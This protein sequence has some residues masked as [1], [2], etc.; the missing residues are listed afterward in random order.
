MPDD[1]I[2]RIANRVRIELEHA[3]NQP[4]RPAPTLAD[5]GQQLGASVDQIRAAMLHLDGEHS[6]TFD[7]EHADGRSERTPTADGRRVTQVPETTR[8]RGISVRQYWLPRPND[9]DLLSPAQQLAFGLQRLPDLTRTS[10]ERVV[11]RVPSLELVDA[12]VRPGRP[13]AV[14]ESVETELHRTRT[15]MAG[16]DREVWEWTGP[17]CVDETDRDEAKRAGGLE[18]WLRQVLGSRCVGV[19]VIH[20]APGAEALF[21]KVWAV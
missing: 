5:L 18:P 20:D 19:Q 12:R 14:L 3:A 11:A 6:V 17:L 4:Q 21:V 2:I 13:T 1:E 16:E 15:P 9:P 7:L 8:I 10:S